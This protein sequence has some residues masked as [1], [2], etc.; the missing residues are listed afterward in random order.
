M[1]FKWSTTGLPLI[2]REL[3]ELSARRRTFIVRAI[4]AILF[5][6]IAFPI[7]L[8]R[9]SNTGGNPL[10]LLGTG[11]D[12]F[13]YLTI[14]QFFGIYLFFPAIMSGAI[15]TE[16]EQQT[17]GLLLLTHLG[18]WSILL[19]KLISRSVSMIVCLFCSLPLLAFCYSLGGLNLNAV[20]YA[21][22]FLSLTLFQVGSLSLM[23]SA[24]ARS[25]VSAVVLSYLTMIGL[26][27]GPFFLDMFVLHGLLANL[28]LDVLSTVHGVE[29][30]YLERELIEFGLVTLFPFLLLTLSSGIPHIHILIQFQIIS[31][32]A[33]AIVP[34][35]LARY[36]LVSRSQTVGG[37]LVLW[38]HSA[39]D[40]IFQR[41]NQ[42]WVT[43]GIILQN[44]SR[45]EPD[46]HPIAWRELSRNSLSQRRYLI[47][48]LLVM[49]VPLLL[50]IL[51]RLKSPSTLRDDQL[52]LAFVTSI[53]WTVAGLLIIV[54]SC[55]LIASERNRQT[56]D[57]LLTLPVSGDEL[58]RQKF[59]GVQRLILIT[60]C[61][62]ITILLFTTWY[63]HLLTGTMIRSIPNQ[64]F[65]ETCLTSGSMILI[66]PFFVAWLSLW[67]SVK[68]KSVQRATLTSLLVVVGWCLLPLLSYL[69]LVVLVQPSSNG[70][71]DMAAEYFFFP[72]LS[73]IW[74][75]VM[76]ESNSLRWYC[77][78][79][80]L[81]LMINTAFYGGLTLLIRWHLLSS[82]DSL[83]GRLSSKTHVIRNKLLLSFPYRT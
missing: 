38:L 11:L 60:L 47:R 79:P 56:L 31:I 42:N 55:G 4:Y 23:F 65:L 24:F 16:K 35:L 67:I 30:L 48:I 58:I 81:P 28:V 72:Q 33:T 46:R 1:R 64:D 44:G 52:L 8:Q 6:V 21:I 76:S 41:L 77:A 20:L 17:L 75:L 73:P 78:W 5:F 13:L 7:I 45:N 53:I 15:A 39:S 71:P 37:S 80:Y 61:P 63:K 34:L 18:P 50:F 3:T 83:L 68:C 43:R 36:F 19:Q 14:V 62:M 49:E 29:P 69:I 74:L 25:S 70:R 9:L 27:L 2:A 40:R 66:Y 10:N 51:D 57:I 32:L 22:A 12:L 82:A 54:A 26:F 59:F